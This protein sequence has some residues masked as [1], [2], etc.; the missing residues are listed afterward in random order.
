LEALE[1]ENAEAEVRVSQVMEAMAKQRETLE[2][3]RA[4][5][6]KAQQRVEE[7]EE[8]GQTRAGAWE[9]EKAVL[10]TELREARDAHAAHSLQVREVKGAANVRVMI[11][12]SSTNYY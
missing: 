12:I 11:Q 10:S 3:E 6:L 1:K 9:L 4:R 7:L 8:A 2:T 5:A